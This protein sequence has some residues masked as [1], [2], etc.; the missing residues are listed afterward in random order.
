M[1]DAILYYIFYSLH[2]QEHDSF[3]AFR[4][5]NLNLD[6]SLKTNPVK[7]NLLD[8]P[9]CPELYASTLRFL[10]KIRNCMFSVTR[11]VR[12]GMLWGVT[13][14]RKLQLTRHYKKIKLSVDFHKF[15]ICHWMS[16][17]KENGAELVADS[18]VLQMCNQLSLVPIEDGLLHR[19]RANW[20]IKYLKCQLGPTRIYLCKNLGKDDQGA[21]SGANMSSSEGLTQEHDRSFFLSVTK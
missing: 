11:P 13:T 7:E 4:S 9:S 3:R 8:I 18:F 16:N 15:T 17:A 19:P 10:E 2:F 1:V 5:Q 21:S 12:R 14:A 6:L 20:S